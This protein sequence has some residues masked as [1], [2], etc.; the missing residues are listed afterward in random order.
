MNKYTDTIL[1]QN[2]TKVCKFHPRKKASNRRLLKKSKFQKN[3]R[4]NIGVN[5]YIALEIRT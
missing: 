2:H 3:R 1:T 5:S 4:W